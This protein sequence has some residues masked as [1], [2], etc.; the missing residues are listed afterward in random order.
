MKISTSSKSSSWLKRL[1]SPQP[2]ICFAQLMLPN[3]DQKGH[4]CSILYTCLHLKIYVP[5]KYLGL[6]SVCGNKSLQIS[7]AAAVMIRFPLWLLDD[8]LLFAWGTWKVNFLSWR[9]ALTHNTMLS[10]LGSI[11]YSQ[12]SCSSSMQ[13]ISLYNAMWCP[14]SSVVMRNEV[15]WSTSFRQSLPSANDA[16]IV[17]FHLLIEAIWCAINNFL[18]AC[19]R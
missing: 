12:V 14:E 8:T 5:L 6:L 11:L 7:V 4:I 15:T 16:S 19:L 13:D 3:P 1:G 10:L 18:L 9:S 2:I 17:S